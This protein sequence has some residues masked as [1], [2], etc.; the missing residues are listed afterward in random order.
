MSEMNGGSHEIY[1][2]RK[3]RMDRSPGAENLDKN[4]T[5]AGFNYRY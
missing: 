2:A 5:L 1:R 3:R 4:W